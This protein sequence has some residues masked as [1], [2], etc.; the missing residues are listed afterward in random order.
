MKQVLVLGGTNF[1]GYNLVQSLIKQESCQVTLFNRG[2]TKPDVFPQLEKIIGDRENEKDLNQIFKKRWDVIIDLSGY[3]PASVKQILDHVNQDLTKYIFIS[4]CSVYD[5]RSYEGQF[6]DEKA[7]LLSCSS[8]EEKDQAVATYG[9][10]KAACERLIE[11]SAISSVIFR[12]A[13]VFG[14][15]DQT[16]RFYYWLYQMKTQQKVLIPEEGQRVFS[17]TSVQDLVRCVVQA[18]DQDKIEGVFNCISYPSISILKIVTACD[19]VWGKQ[20][21]LVSA[22]AAFLQKR[23]ISEWTDL[24]LWLHSDDFTYSNQALKAQFDF[25]PTRFEQRLMETIA[26]FEERGFD[27]PAVGI[28][29]LMKQQLISEIETDEKLLGNQ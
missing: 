20:P 13:L 22:T 28:D 18:I 23:H 9:R 14:P 10:R 25:V 11:A 27:P 1:I 5:N 29:D 17:I 24:P 4:T 7:P 15:E 8:Q 26:F 19:Q 16:D 3:Y 21:E 12:P 2:V 6:R